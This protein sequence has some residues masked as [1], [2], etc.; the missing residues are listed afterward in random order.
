MSQLDCT[1]PYWKYRPLYGQLVS[2]CTTEAQ[3]DEANRKLS[4][5]TNT[6]SLYDKPC[7]EMLLLSM[8]AVN[9]DPKNTPEDI[10]I[11]FQYTEK[12]YEEIVQY[13]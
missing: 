5:I 11:A 13:K 10:G 6:L 2:K 7:T 3:L 4:N 1:P 12:L 9:G 8:N